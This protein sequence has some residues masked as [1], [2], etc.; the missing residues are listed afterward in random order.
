MFFCLFFFLLY[1]IDISLAEPLCFLLNELRS[2]R[3]TIPL[4]VCPLF[5]KELLKI[6][7]KVLFQPFVYLYAPFKRSFV[8]CNLITEIKCTHHYPVV[9]AEKQNNTCFN[10]I[11]INSTPPHKKQKKKNNTNTEI[12]ACRS[13]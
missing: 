1:P 2:K 4:S 10:Q 9:A 5:A 13:E 8:S 11:V 12:I 7:L 6:H 3:N